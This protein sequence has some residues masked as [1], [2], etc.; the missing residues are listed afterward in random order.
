LSLKYGSFKIDPNR[1][2]ISI[3]IPP[4][5]PEKFSHYDS[6]KNFNSVS[7]FEKKFNFML[8]CSHLFAHENVEKFQI[9]KSE[10]YFILEFSY[11]QKIFP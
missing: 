11:L 1:T 5:K 10:A 3:K 8:R 7:M 6:N 9:G 2:I 4:L